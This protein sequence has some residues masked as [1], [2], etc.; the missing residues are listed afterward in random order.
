LP[1]SAFFY[2]AAIGDWEGSLQLVE[3]TGA[4]AATTQILKYTVREERPNEPEGSHGR[5]F[6]SGH[7]SFAFSGAAYWQRRYG[8][9]VGAPTYIAASY[10]GYS[11]VHASK[12]NW[13]DVAAGAAIG[14]GFNYMFT[15]PWAGISVMPTDGGAAISLHK[16]F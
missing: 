13:A 15:T 9:Q 1:L 16:T 2:S 12:H 14:I 3:A 4:A 7:T 8:W 5:T 10:V 6:P 11:R